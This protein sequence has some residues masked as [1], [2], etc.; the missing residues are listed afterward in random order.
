MPAQAPTPELRYFLYLDNELVAEFLAQLEEGEFETFVLEQSRENVAELEAK[1]G[2]AGIGI[3]GSDHQAALARSTYSMRLTPASQFARL[4]RLTRASGWLKEGTESLQ[5]VHQGD[6][7]LFAG[8][9]ELTG[10][11]RLALGLRDLDRSSQYFDRIARPVRPSRRQAL[12]ELV[13]DKLRRGTKWTRS[14][15]TASRMEGAETPIIVTVRG[16]E[17]RVLV[18][19]RR[20][21]FRVEPTRLPGERRLLLKVNRVLTTGE[22]LEAADFLPGAPGFAEHFRLGLQHSDE[23]TELLGPM[24]LGYPGLVG[25]ALGIYEP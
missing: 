21:K 13:D 5:R 20:D 12:M 1:A 3:Q 6:L 10:I 2:V 4:I 8:T 23:S 9:I 15:V 25:T 22:Q 24:V 7:V 14:A 11:S 19:L 16:I 17:T 18:R